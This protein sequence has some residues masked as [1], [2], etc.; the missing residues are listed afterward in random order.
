MYDNNNTIWNRLKYHNKSENKKKHIKVLKYKIDFFHLD[1]NGFLTPEN[2][3]K[4]KEKQRGKEKTQHTYEMS[5][6]CFKH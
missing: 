3:K 6:K 2:K 4:K 1:K 5:K